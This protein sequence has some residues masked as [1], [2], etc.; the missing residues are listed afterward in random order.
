MSFTCALA[1]FETECARIEVLDSADR[2]HIARWA[3]DDR[4]ETVWQRIQKLAWGPV[5]TYDPLDGFI[6]IILVAR[7]M[8][9]SISILPRIDERS[10]IRSARH[11]ERAHD[12]EA[13]A[14]AW[15][16]IG[17]RMFGRTGLVDMIYLI[18]IY[19]LSCA[20][21]NAFEIPSPE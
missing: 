10:K 12:L 4:S 7:R 14:K 18:G 3:D 6:A 8:A 11:L 13:L 2:D 21:L 9:D 17:N 5:E 1:R 15:K 20:M 19:L 16:D